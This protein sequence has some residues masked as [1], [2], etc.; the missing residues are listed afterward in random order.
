MNPK[1]KWLLMLEGGFILAVVGLSQFNPPTLPLSFLPFFALAVLRMARTLSFNEV[2]E[3]LRQPFTNVVPDSCGAG[4]NVHPKPGTGLRHVIG[5]LLACPICTA[6][7]SA[8]V[9]YGLWVIFP[10]FGKTLVYVLAF[11]GAAEVVHWG[12][13]S[14]EWVGRAAR[15][16]SGLISPDNREEK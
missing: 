7:W 5:S 10:A 16:V 2:A 11:A 14:L 8:L 6:T 1:F 13:E 12:A 3:P 9:L 15:C 4:D